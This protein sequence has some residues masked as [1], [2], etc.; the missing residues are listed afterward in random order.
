MD[1]REQAWGGARP[2]NPIMPSCNHARFVARFVLH[3]NLSPAILAATM[4]LKHAFASLAIVLLSGALVLA[5]VRWLPFVRGAENI[6]Y[7]ARIAYL[8]T[9]T[10]QS[11]RIVLVVVTESTLAGFPYRSPLDRAF[12]ADLIEHL[13]TAG[14]R[15]IGLDILLDQPTEPDKDARLAEILAAA[16]VPIVAITGDQRD[17]LTEAQQAY[18]EA[19]LGAV[20]TAFASLPGDVYDGAVRRHDPD[21]PG[22]AGPQPSFAAALAA[23][24]GTAAPEGSFRLTY[25][26]RPDPSR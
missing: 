16:P 14:V 3:P 17:G 12:L 18:L 15:A 23:S 13:G 9:A 4:S 10:P 22:P 5:A 8:G 6:T 24:V 20:T 25:R 26:P 7:D 2:R 21:R 11:D 19:M 1:G